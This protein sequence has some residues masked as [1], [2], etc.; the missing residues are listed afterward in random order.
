MATPRNDGGLW[1]EMLKIATYAP[2]PLFAENMRVQM[3]FIMVLFGSQAFF[4]CLT[5]CIKDLHKL[6][7]MDDLELFGHFEGDNTAEVVSLRHGNTFQLA[8]KAVLDFCGLTGRRSKTNLYAVS[9]AAW[10]ATVVN[11]TFVLPRSCAYNSPTRQTNW[12]LKICQVV[13]AL[14]VLALVSTSAI[15]ASYRMFAGTI[16]LGC[17]ISCV[18]ILY[19]LR[20]QCQLVFSNKEALA[21][22]V[23]G[24][25]PGGAALD[26]HIS[27]GNWNASRFDIVCGYSSQLHSLTNI[28]IRVKDT[29]SLNIAGKVVTLVLVLQAATLAS[30]FGTTSLD[31]W[32]C[33]IWLCAYLLMSLPP[34][35][36]RDH[37]PDVLHSRLNAQFLAVPPIQFSGRKS[38]LAFI[39]MLPVT[40]KDEQRWAWLDVFMPSNQRRKIFESDL[41]T[42]PL[43]SCTPL[44]EH[45]TKVGS[46][47]KTPSLSSQCIAEATAV[48]QSPR[49]SEQLEIFKAVVYKTQNP[50]STNMVNK[51]STPLNETV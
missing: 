31:S 18:A 9:G 23:R 43:I 19:W 28:P 33:L 45:E 1:Q 44:S 3:S 32:S 42:S 8:N 15:V 10:R 14:E 2:I 51:S 16:L 17:I 20:Q 34:K 22:D 7:D 35:I 6:W 38:A 48:F 21:R 29:K 5:G 26:I 46:D 25:V 41:E 50:Q 11:I 39:A 37:Y 36:L 30:L 40:S 27:G 13:Q 12:I 49:F 47:P 24:G 4:S